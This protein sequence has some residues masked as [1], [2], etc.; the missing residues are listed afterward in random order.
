MHRQ[1]SVPEFFNRYAHDFDALYG[2][3]NGL[4]NRL[5]NRYFRRSMKLRFEKTIEGCDPIQGRSVIDVG[6]G[7]GLYAV[8][9][10]RRGAGPVVGIDL[11]EAMLSIARRRAHETG[12]AKRCSW[13]H[14][15]FLTYPAQRKFDYAIVMGFMDYV[16]DPIP[17]VRKVLSIANRRAFFSFPLDG[18]F[19]AW[20]RKA[21][22]RSRC[23]LFMYS[24]ERVR[25]LF[26]DATT[27]PVEI[28]PI[29]RDL[30]VSVH[31]TE[32]ESPATEAH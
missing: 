22:Y 9:L 27:R 6:C 30:F 21:R 16:A 7:P 18:G 19:M 32:D 24:A 23:P 28:K 10:A 11:A 15:D 26:R 25:G 2:T 31:V 17:L 13:V 14:G 1:P 5:V 8:T 20:Q 4:F 29:G 3:R 12:V